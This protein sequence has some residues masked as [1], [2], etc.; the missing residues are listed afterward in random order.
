MERYSILIIDI[1]AD[2]YNPILQ[3]F[4]SRLLFYV[5]FILEKDARNTVMRNDKSLK[6][7][8]NWTDIYMQNNGIESLC[9]YIFPHYFKMD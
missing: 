3:F 7:W 8:E 9:H 1:V 5:Q 6:C 2:V 4:L